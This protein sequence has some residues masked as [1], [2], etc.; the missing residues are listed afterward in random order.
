MLEMRKSD[1][2]RP[3][4]ALANERRLERAH[5][6]D[7]PEHQADEQQ[8]LP[9][10]S[11]VDVFITLAAK[12]EPH[13]AEPLLDAQPLASERTADHEHQR[14][15]EYIHAEP[16]ILWLVATDGRADIEPRRQP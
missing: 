1:E 4:F 2:Q 12:P 7:E 9:E 10:P 13:V 15:E 8:N 6:Q 14:A 3:V 16:L 5:H 11:Q